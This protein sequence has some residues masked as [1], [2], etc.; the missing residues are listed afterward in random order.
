VDTKEAQAWNA[1]YAAGRYVGEP[2]VD[3]VNDIV[4]CAWDA[5]FRG[6]LGLYIGCGNGRNYLPLVDAGLDLIGLDI[7]A[8]AIEQLAMRA[9]SRRDRLVV[10]DLSA[11]P[12]DE[13]YRLV[14]GIQVFQHG[15]RAES[16][17]FVGDAL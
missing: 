3:F 8:K 17:A 1:E 13:T 5:V 12:A 11:L 7:S 9:P 10:G 14:V 2:P 4:V 16:H 6:A 15:D